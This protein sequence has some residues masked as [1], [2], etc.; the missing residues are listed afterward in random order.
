MEGFV[1]IVFR[2]KSSRT[3]Q[4]D[5]NV[6]QRMKGLIVHKDSDKTGGYYL[7]DGER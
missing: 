6:I 3:I 1:K 7:K 2:R 5:L 4:S